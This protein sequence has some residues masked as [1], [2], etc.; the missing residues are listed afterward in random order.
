MCFFYGNQTKLFLT[1]RLLKAKHITSWGQMSKEKIKE[2]CS[3][4][5][6]GCK[7]KDSEFALCKKNLL[8][9]KIC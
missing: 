3:K 4:L 7:K 5:E 2:L 6:N 1:E 8:S 9:K